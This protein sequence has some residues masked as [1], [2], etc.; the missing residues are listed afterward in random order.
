MFL[1]E[2]YHSLD[3]KGRVVMPSGFRRGLEEGCVLT[4]G[5]DGQLFLFPT[6]EFE[7]RAV[8]VRAAQQNRA[9]RRFSRTVFSGADLQELDKS[10]RVLV[11]PDLRDFAS[12]LLLEQLGPR[13][14]Q[15]LA[16]IAEVVHGTPTR[17]DDPARFSFAH[18]GKDG[19]PFPVPLDTYDQSIAV[20]RRAL[21]AAKLGRSDKL[22]GMSRLDTFTRAIEDRGAPEADVAATINYERRLSRSL[23]GRTV[24]D[25]HRRKAGV[26]LRPARLAAHR[27]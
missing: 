23:G 27:A 12:F 10:G 26:H 2:Y 13:T 14:L 18:G 7:A 5:Q 15:S 19:H 6:H 21:D 8:E 24:F 22:E 17:F 25:D 1:G 4:K 9:G 11:K 3:G 20:L 16:L